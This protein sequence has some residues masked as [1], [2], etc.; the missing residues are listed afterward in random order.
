MFNSLEHRRVCGGRL[1]TALSL[2]CA[3]SVA[4]ATSAERFPGIGRTA[5]PAEIRA[6]DI[7][8]RPDFAGLPPGAGSVARGQQVWEAQCASCHGVFGESNEVFSPLVGGTT[9]QDMLTGRVARLTDPS[10]P[11]R[12]TMMKLSQ[13]STLWDYIRRAMPWTQPKSLSVDDV[14]AVTAYLLNLSG[15]VEEDFV[16][17]Q[18]NIAQ[19]QQRLPNRHGMTT[20]HA[21]WPGPEFSGT[22][23]PDVQGSSCMRNCPVEPKVTSYLPEHARDA[24]GN[25]AEQNRLVGPQ[26]GAVTTRTAA[27][28]P[29]A[30]AADRGA[31]PTALLQQH[32]CTACHGMDR[33]QVGPSF[34]EI[35]QRYAHRSDAADY[36]RSKIIA[37]GVG[38][39]G[40][41]PMPAQSLPESD[42][43]AIA[44][45]LARGATRP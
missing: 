35:A 36:L 24:H 39:W 18:H 29:A 14:Y 44:E 17:S 45:W 43:Q 6:W 27:A 40:Q 2:A 34:Q 5:T 11:G 42:A 3:A 12:T 16:L 9:R 4:L 26:R 21:M 13:V 22:A 38:V 20:A 37:G 1:L 23:K 10:F 7:D 28:A 19:V 15:V 25:L 32:A 30:A 8:V 41:I 33:T 31:V